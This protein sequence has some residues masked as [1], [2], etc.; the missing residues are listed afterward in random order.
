MVYFQEA[1]PTSDLTSWTVNTSTPYPFRIRMAPPYKGNYHVTFKV[2]Y[3]NNGS[4]STI[5]L[6]GTTLGS[7]PNATSTLSLDFDGADNNSG[8]A[9]AK[10]YLQVGNDKRHLRHGYV[11][12][13]FFPIGMNVPQGVFSNSNDDIAPL[14]TPL[15]LSNRRNEFTQL[16]G[17][18]GNYARILSFGDRGDNI[19]GG[20]ANCVEITHRGDNDPY[21]LIGN[22]QIN[23]DKMGETDH[24]IE[25][26]ENNGIFITWCL[27]TYGFDDM[28]DTNHYYATWPINPYKYELNHIE[29]TD[30]FTESDCQKFFKNRLRY[31]Q[32]RWG[33][34]ASIAIYQLEVK[35]MI[36]V[37]MG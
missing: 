20:G 35:L 1:A 5:D 2:T 11:K 16:A 6:S 27:Q 13:S 18:G 8:K 15:G 3:W 7:Q 14:N 19:T 26:F 17:N 21:F 12:T 33:Y 36:L 30:F 28:P 34:S 37:D 23:Q 31:I 22:Y 32:S 4:Y 29:V 25:C 24:D 9:I 10:G